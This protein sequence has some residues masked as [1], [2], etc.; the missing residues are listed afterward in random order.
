MTHQLP[1]QVPNRHV[2][3]IYQAARLTYMT[4]HDLV[5]DC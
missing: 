1:G 2:Y 5:S 3:S 4:Q